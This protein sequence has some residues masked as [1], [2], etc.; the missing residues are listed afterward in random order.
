M[1]GLINFE[2]EKEVKE[3]LDNL[4]VEYSYQC[5]REKS[6]EGKMLSLV[7]GMQKGLLYAMCFVVLLDIHLIIFRMFNAFCLAPCRVPAAG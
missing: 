1:A 4:G 2:D 6:P 3:F 7:T 5:Y